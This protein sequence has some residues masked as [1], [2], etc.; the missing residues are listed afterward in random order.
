[1]TAA[2]ASGGPWARIRTTFAEYRSLDRRVH[3]LAFA[4]AVNTVGFS[5]VLPFMAVYLHKTRGVSGF[6]YGAIYFVAGVAS[7]LSQ[8]LA[9]ELADRYGRRVVMLTGLCTRAVNLAALGL[10]IERHASI[11][12]LACLVISNATLRGLFEPAASAAVADLTPPERRV[13][14]YGLQKIG[15]NVGWALGPA[16]GGYLTSASYGLMFYCAAPVTLLA[17]WAAAQ[18]RDADLQR[19]VARRGEAPAQAAN[20]TGSASA[21]S[22]LPVEFLVLLALAFF[23]S[24]AT[25]QV[26]STLSVYSEELLHLPRSRVGLIY[27]INGVIVVAL[28]I[29]AVALIGRVGIGRAL[30]FGP[31]M[32]ALGYVA[33][34]WAGGFAVLATVM[35]FITLGEMMLSPAQTS[36][37]ADLGD[38]A[39]LGRA[40]GLFGLA[41]QFGVSVGPVV[42]GLAIDHLGHSH[43]TMWLTLAALPALVAVGYG[44]MARRIVRRAQR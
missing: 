44:V 29:P 14:A 24:V 22:K 41:Q 5:I 17:A 10:A 15:V 27:T 9:G 7:A 31:V 30:V 36:T 2:P 21:H 13:A 35:A 28:Q 34:G 11:A 3:W 20:L 23:M 26:F 18:V 1:M 40:M 37:A 16:I 42:G 25:T 12:V 19:L 4:R 39:R 38:P 8:G 6:G 33:F 32:Y 43:I